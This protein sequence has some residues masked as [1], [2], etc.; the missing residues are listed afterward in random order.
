MTFETRSCTSGL[1][2][3]GQR[4]PLSAVGWEQGICKEYSAFLYNIQGQMLLSD[5]L[6]VLHVLRGIGLQCQETVWV[7]LG[8]Q[9][10]RLK[11][12]PS[13]STGTP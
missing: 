8:M 9:I 5:S 11:V 10:I 3:S 2:N 13:P 1:S 12:L 6:R 7:P 4:K